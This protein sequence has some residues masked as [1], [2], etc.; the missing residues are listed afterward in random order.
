MRHI[1]TVV[2]WCLVRCAFP[3]SAQYHQVC[4]CALFVLS[5]SGFF[6]KTAESPACHRRTWPPSVVHIPPALA[7]PWLQRPLPMERRQRGRSDNLS[8]GHPTLL[9]QCL[10]HLYRLCCALMAERGKTFELLG[11]GFILCTKRYRRLRVGTCT[12]I[13]KPRLSHVH[14]HSPHL[15][16]LVLVLLQ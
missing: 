10:V 1:F 11:Q 9:P 4:M 3:E 13:L 16:L 14:D 15:V 8:I 12:G 6:S 2:K 5:C 7:H